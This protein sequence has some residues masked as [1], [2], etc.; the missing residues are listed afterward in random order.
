MG[1]EA[2]LILASEQNGFTIAA[3]LRSLS[4]LAT[5]RYHAQVLATGALVPAVAVSMDERLD[6]LARELRTDARQL[7]HVEDA[8]LAPRL[9]LAMDFAWEQAPAIRDVLAASLA[10]SRDTLD[11]MGA[12]LVDELQAKRAALRA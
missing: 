4:L 11:A 12:W 3:A 8:D 5:S 1:G 9:L 6:N 2:P 10:R 7:L